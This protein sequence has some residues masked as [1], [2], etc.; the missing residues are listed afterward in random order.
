MAGDCGLTEIGKRTKLERR[1][2][3]AL[4]HPEQ[5]AWTETL[6]LRYERWE[7]ET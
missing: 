2:S 5:R 7:E 3:M 1:S 6:A 4:R